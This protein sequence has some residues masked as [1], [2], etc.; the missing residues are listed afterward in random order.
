MQFLKIPKADVKTIIVI[1]FREAGLFIAAVFLLFFDGIYFNTNVIESQLMLNILMGL[2]FLAMLYR[3]NS[4]A[5]K[6]MIIG[7]VLGFVGEHFFSRV[8]G[9]YTYRLDNVPLYVPFGHGVLY[10]RIFRF[11]KAS[12]VKKYHKQIESFLSILMIIVAAIYMLFFNDLF[13]FIMTIVVFL[14]LWK[15][16]KERL[17]FFSM[18]MLVV[19]LEIGGTA[20]GAWKWPNTAFGIFE[21]LPSNNPPSGISLF[22][23]LLDIGC[24]VF[25]IQLNKKAWK[26]L[27]RIRKYQLN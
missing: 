4:R 2:A 23:F 18:Y 27:K 12:L 22:Y 13:G 21:F 16:P 11:S 10:A 20:F 24:F 25:Y 19:V 8:L 1:F 3:A 26:R 15:R 9:M 5:R 14:I 6:L 7:V 17:F